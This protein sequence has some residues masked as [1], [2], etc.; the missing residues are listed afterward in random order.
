MHCH[1]RYCRFV[2]SHWSYLTR[3]AQFWGLF[4]YA[5][6]NVVASH[7]VNGNAPQWHMALKTRSPGECFLS[8]TEPDCRRMARILALPGHYRGLVSICDKASCCKTQQSLKPTRLGVKILVELWKLTCNSAGV[9]PK[10]LPNFRAIGKL[11]IPNSR[12]LD[13][14][15]LT[16]KCLMQ[17]WIGPQVVY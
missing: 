10:H 16:I 8:G 11:Q 12:F 13:L 5:I 4:H 7:S 3:P 17:Y 9:L 6:G 15:D 14:R 2:L 1:W